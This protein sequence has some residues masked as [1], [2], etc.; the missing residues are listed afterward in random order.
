MNSIY[1][2]N[3]E[4]ALPADEFWGLLKGKKLI[5][6]TVSF[7]NVS[8]LVT[9]LLIINLKCHKVAR[10]NQEYLYPF[11]SPQDH[12]AGS[13]K[14]RFDEESRNNADVCTGLELYYSEKHSLAI[15]QQRSP[16]LPGFEKLYLD[17]VFIPFLN[18]SKI[19][20]LIILDSSSFSDINSSISDSL[21]DRNIAVYS[22]LNIEIAD[23]LKFLKI[24][25]GDKVFD[26]SEYLKNQENNSNIF[27]KLFVEL[28]LR[29][30]SS[31][32]TNELV[33]EITN[34]TILQMFVFEGDNFEDALSYFFYI[35]NCVLLVKISQDQCI[36]P[37]LWDSLYGDK[38]IPVSMEEGIFC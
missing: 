37:Y 16:L 20:E 30:S 17:E 25:D 9:D 31:E 15:I 13:L 34:V 14:D 6:P 23:R 19:L 35:M 1:S 29:Q 10:I 38:P 26:I 18:Q 22:Q 5:V 28:L 36:M 12:A 21:N 3:N 11:V 32:K 27:I 8:Q 4:Q 24:N 33:L 2:L 7:A